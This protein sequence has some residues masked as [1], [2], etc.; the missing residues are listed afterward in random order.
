MDNNKIGKFILNMRKEKN[1]TQKELGDKLFV[2]DKAVSKW[3]R[4]V[5]LPDIT[6]LNKLSKILGVS[7]NDILD[8]TK[9]SNRK[10]DVN[11]EIENIKEMMNKKHKSKV[12]KILLC[13][14][15]LV[16]V[17]IYLIFKNI[18]LGYDIKT[19]HYN[20]TD[21]N[22]NIGIPKLSFM[23]KNNDRS[24]SFKNFRSAGI[25]ENEVK[26]YLKTL[27]YSTCNNTIYYYNEKDNYSIIN[28]SVKNHFLYSTIS[29]EIVEK[30]FCFT[31]KMN[32][33]SKK[34]SGLRKFH[35]M[36]GDGI[37]LSKDVYFKPR[38]VV[39]FKDDIDNKKQNF[40]A[41]L[42]VRYLHQKDN[43]WDK[44]LQEEIEKSE[45][46]YEIKEDKLYYYRSKIDKKIDGINI[47]DVS[48]FKIEDGSLILIDNYLSSYEES[49]ILK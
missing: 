9:E 28:Y 3:E 23:L 37:S 14:A 34:L 30:D 33:Y 24:Y 32:E 21:R 16:I 38:L 11:K 44:I 19:V 18:S 46:T 25:L 10:I 48:A 29:Y 8:G 12:K 4:G 43:Y 35:T 22:I 41:E 36:N 20:H 2:T 26:K 13:L 47:P 39:Y 17:I 27:K 6:M 40:N 7:V 1:L 49:I 15:L 5:S 31:N 45:G 42:T